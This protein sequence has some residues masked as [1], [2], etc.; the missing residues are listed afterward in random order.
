MVA[1]LIRQIRPWF[2]G[3]REHRA[4]RAGFNL[5]MFSI[6][7]AGQASAQA[8]MSLLL[9]PF[10]RRNRGGWSSIGA[11]PAKELFE[12]RDGGLQAR[13]RFSNAPSY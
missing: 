3:A 13:H 11:R 1:T 12:M 5:S 8:C 9:H 6:C 2:V 7:V 4:A 10:H